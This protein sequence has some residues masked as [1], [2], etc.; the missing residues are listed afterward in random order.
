LLKENNFQIIAQKSAQFCEITVS[1]RKSSSYI[2]DEIFTAHNGI[3]AEQ[4]N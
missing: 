3:L 2:F 4:I 1:A